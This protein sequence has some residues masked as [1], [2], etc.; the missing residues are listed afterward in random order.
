MSTISKGAIKTSH[1][2]ADVRTKVRAMC[3]FY[4]WLR[5]HFYSLPGAGESPGVV[6]LETPVTN[7]SL[8]DGHTWSLNLATRDE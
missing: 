3:I 8:V 4:L 2:V 7:V 6:A 5:S 1:D